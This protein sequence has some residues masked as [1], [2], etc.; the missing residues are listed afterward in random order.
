MKIKFAKFY[1]YLK[2]NWNSI[3]AL[4]SILGIITFNFI[5][6]NHDY[7]NYFIFLIINAIIWTLVEI[8]IAIKHKYLK[9]RF[10]DMREARSHIIQSIISR[11]KKNKGTNLD[12]QIVGGRI[13]T[14]SD[15]LREIKNQITNKGLFIKNTKFTIYCMHPELLRAMKY[16]KTREDISIQNRNKIYAQLVEQFSAE[17]M[18]YNNLDLFK[19]NGISIEIIY[20]RQDPIIY[21]FLIGNSEIYWGN[22]TWTSEREDFEGPINRCYYLE[23]NDEEFSDYYY[24]IS[25]RIEYYNYLYK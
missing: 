7:I 20:Y 23:E 8:K 2:Q 21:A 4:I 24:W 15:M 5:P 9:V 19:K 17:L 6:N 18:D 14:I 10:D 12:I 22:F 3:I 11:I 13:R 16:K 1:N 25:N